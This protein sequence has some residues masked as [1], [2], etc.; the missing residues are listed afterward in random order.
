MPHDTVIAVSRPICLSVCLSLRVG[1]IKQEIL[2]LSKETPQGY[3]AVTIRVS[4]VY[5][6]VLTEPLGRQDWLSSTF[7]D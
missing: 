7:F 2:V 4:D 3:P 1:T 5:G 6:R